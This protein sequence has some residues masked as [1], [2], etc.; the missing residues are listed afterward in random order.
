MTAPESYHRRVSHRG[1]LP[2]RLDVNEGLRVKSVTRDSPA[3]SAGVRAGDEVL[4]LDGQ[5]RWRVAPF[6]EL[7]AQAVRAVFQRTICRRSPHVT[8]TPPG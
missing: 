1:V 4:R 3:E 8:R 7:P 5:A 2:S 6:P